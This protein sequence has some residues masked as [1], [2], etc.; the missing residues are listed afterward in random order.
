MEAVYNDYQTKDVEFFYVYKSLAHPGKDG[1]PQPV[2][3]DERLA[4]IARAKVEYGT[5]IPWIADTIENDLKHAL[6]N[7]NNSEFVI[8]P[9][10]KI[11]IAREWSDPEL[12]R[13]DL[14]GLVG[15]PETLTKISDL[16]L[17]KSSMDRPGVAR[18]IV[19]TIPLSAAT[20]PLLV[21]AHPSEKD[22]PLYLKLR[23]EVPR[24]AIQS[25]EKTKMH[26]DFRLDPIHAVHWNN[27]AAPMK[28]EI[29][30]PEGVTVTPSAQSA[31]KIEEKADSD[32]RQFLVDIDPGEADAIGPL[33]VKAD[34]FACDDNDQWCKA[35]TQ[36]F[37]ITWE[38]DRDAG[39]VQSSMGRRRPIAPDSRGLDP[40]RVM[41][42]LD[43]N[44]D[45]EI[46]EEE[47]WGPI[48]RRFS[49][50]DENEDGKLTLEELEAAI[51]L[52]K[53]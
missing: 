42:R 45:G 8:D 36:E 21:T 30:A 22:Q 7:K 12:L 41:S 3:L 47:A 27:L 23:A 13:E 34:F 40:R 29:T 17:E 2:T 15:E 51:P 16:D 28:F 48:G 38:I 39:K 9:D 37:T 50:I 11:L 10:G 25:P 26:L 46:S 1:Y 5:R 44:E 18:D 31:P 49:Q 35:V 24:A 20:E 32:P 4:H 43:S 53:R 6:G 33:Q 52:V 19:P 14:A